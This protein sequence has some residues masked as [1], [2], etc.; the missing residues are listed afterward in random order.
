MSDQIKISGIEIDFAILRGRNLVAKDRNIFNQKTTSDPYVKFYLDGKYRGQTKV[1][2]KDLNPTWNHKFKINLST[3]E[4]NNMVAKFKNGEEP[5]FSLCIFDKDEFS[6]D[7][8]MGVVRGK[9]SLTD[10]PCTK[11]MKVEKST[12]DSKPVTGEVE[13][14]MAVSVRKLLTAT[15]GSSL[16]VKGTIKVNLSWNIENGSNTDLDTSCVAVASNGSVLMNET[17]YFAKLENSN[18]SVKH[19]GDVQSGGG[20]GEIITCNLHLIKRQV[21][22]L[23]FILTVATPDKS[24]EDVTSAMVSVE[25]CDTRCTLCHFTPSIVGDNTAMFLMRFLRE[26]DG[27]SWV[28]TII[29]DTDHTAR[30]FGTLIPELK[31]YSKDFAPHVVVDPHDRIAIMRKGGAPIRLRDYGSTN[32]PIPHKVTFGLAWDVTNG[33]N[34]DLDASVICLDSSS[35]SLD[36]IYFRKLRSMDGAIIH[37]GDERE[38]D[39]EGDDEKIYLNLELLNRNVAE[40]V[41]VIT[42]YSGQELDDVSKA[43]CHLFDT[44]SN[45]D[46]ASYTLS[47]NHALDKKRGLI[48][49]SL[50]KDSDESWCMRII[51]EPSAVGKVPQD[52][53]EKTKSFLKNN[54]PIP[55]AVAP[56]PE[57][58]VNEMPQDVDITVDPSGVPIHEVANKIFIPGVDTPVIPMSGVASSAPAAGNN[59]F[60]PKY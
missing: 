52:L 46:I 13:V 12:S 40:L 33:R 25:N 5:Q 53:V 35:R 50:Y 20:K 10:K 56:E 51:S 24:F 15:R 26:D 34:I 41:F 3:D 19:S 49:A 38:G 54:P 37:G 60:V 22:A 23:Y 44:L 14:K 16:G 55:P 42:S 1:V 27:Y 9:L 21:K 58:I 48:M 59:V 17:V 2:W 6:E 39:E 31:G 18:A 8:N 57:I 30:D 4:S 11:W 45:A 28:M 47:N 7:D 29:E 43:S 36:I 32:Q